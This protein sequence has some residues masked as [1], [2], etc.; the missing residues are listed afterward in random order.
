VDLTRAEIRIVA[1]T[2]KGRRE[3]VIPLDAALVALLAAWRQENPEE[4]NVLPWPFPTEKQLYV[5]LDRIEVAAGVKFVPKNLRSTCGTE[6]A[7]DGENLAVIR[8]ILGHS[9]IA[10][11][12]KYYTNTVSVRNKHC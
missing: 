6:L 5:D 1:T 9:T 4:D 10:T 8:D 3:R 11:T 12:A 7:E 2:S